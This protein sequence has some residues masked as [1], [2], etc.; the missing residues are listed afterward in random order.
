MM[1]RAICLLIISLKKVPSRLNTLTVFAESMYTHVKLIFSNS[2]QF[3]HHILLITN[4]CVN[5]KPFNLSYNMETRWGSLVEAGS[6]SAVSK[7]FAG[8]Q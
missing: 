3:C 6:T 7:L 1:Q 4:N 2:T 5:Q 8:I